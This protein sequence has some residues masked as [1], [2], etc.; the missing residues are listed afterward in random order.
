M[1]KVFFASIGLFLA[2][3]LVCTNVSVAHPLTNPNTTK[4]ILKG[5]TPGSQ[6]LKVPVIFNVRLVERNRKRKLYDI[7]WDYKNI[8]PDSKAKA[9]LLKGGHYYCDIRHNVKISYKSIGISMDRVCQNGLRPQNPTDNDY[10]IEVALENQ[11]SIKGRTAKLRLPLYPDLRI[12]DI[13]RWKE[14]GFHKVSWYFY[15]IKVENVGVASTSYWIRF[16]LTDLDT[17]ESVTVEDGS[18]GIRPGHEERITIGNRQKTYDPLMLAEHKRVRV[19]V[20]VF[21]RASEYDENN[22]QLIAEFD[23]VNRLK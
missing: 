7:V 1:F 9:I 13:I 2:A 17:G 15:T 14:K 16:K 18:W 8:D 22:N 12:K 5:K 11:P 6:T 10:Q 4:A 20:Q 19:E 21:T 23:G 3:T